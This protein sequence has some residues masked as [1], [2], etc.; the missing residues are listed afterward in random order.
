MSESLTAHDSTIREP[1]FDF[2]EEKY[3]KIRILEEKQIGNVRA[4]VVMVTPDA[5]YGLEIKSDNDSYTRLEAQVK[6]YN[7][8]YDYN[9]VAVGSS[10]A[11]HI[12]EHV[13]EWWGIISVEEINGKLDFYVL[14]EAKP[15]PKVKPAYKIKILWRPEL[16]RIQAKNRLPVYKEKSKSFVQKAVLDRVPEE[17]LWAQVSEELFERDYNTIENEIKEFKGKKKK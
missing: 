16:A 17:I 8:Y 1:L 5:L 14:R 10:H 13:P 7:L 11:G 12:A 15:N 9:I 6:N 4:D 2:L 3:G